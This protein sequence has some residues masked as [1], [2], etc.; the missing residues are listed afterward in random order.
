MS[1]SAPYNLPSLSPP[2]YSHL[3]SPRPLAVTVLP[4]APVLMQARLMHGTTGQSC[5][6]GTRKEVTGLDL[7]ELQAESLLWHK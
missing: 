5:V 7:L 2:T 6:E 4:G 3:C 1:T